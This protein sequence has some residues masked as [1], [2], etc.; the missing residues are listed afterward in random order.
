VCT[1]EAW[2]N[3]S[4][5]CSNATRSSPNAWSSCG[6]IFD[7]PAAAKHIAAIEQK[8]SAPDFW[9]DQEKAQA[10]LQERKQL[11]DRVNAEKSL[12]GKASDIETYFHLAQEEADHAQ[13]EA[14]L[15]DVAKEIAAA[16]ALASGLE[17]KT[18]L[19]RDNDNLNAILTVKPGAGGIDSQD[20]A[21]MLLRMYLRWAEDKGFRTNVL[22]STPGEEAGVKS[23]TVQIEGENA[24]G[25]LSGESGVHRLVRISPFDQQARRH[26][27]FAS[28]FVIPEIDDRIEIVVNPDDLRVDTFRSGGKGGQNVNKVETA[29]RITHIPT[30]IVVQCQS[31]RSQHKNRETAMKLLRSHLYERELEKRREEA[32]KLDASKPEISFGSQ[33]RSYVMQPYQMIKDHR[34]KVE[35]GDVQKVLDGDI[36]SFI[37][38]YLLYRRDGRQGHDGDEPSN[39]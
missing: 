36:D 14:I 9:D 4:T 19:G 32:R 3:T 17:T 6:V 26:T 34:T 15:D 5:T 20:W 1:I 16:D 30:G 38:A 33:I 21:E 39:E 31:E 8:I 7:A 2:L 11:E 25:M 27:S 24:Y 37:Q 28:V 23:A 12:V 13:R 29:I 10:V 18:L 22:D 35:R